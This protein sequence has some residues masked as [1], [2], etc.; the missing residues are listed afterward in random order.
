MA[1]EVHQQ[2]VIG[3]AVGGEELRDCLIDLESG[4]VEKRPHLEPADVGV[5][6]HP[7]ERLGVLRRRTQPPQPR[8]AVVVAGDDQGAARAVHR[9][10]TGLC[11]D[12]ATRR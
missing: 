7:G 5:S 12:G 10:V 8:V 2:Q 3:V 1:G 4:R 6:E 11:G 9:T